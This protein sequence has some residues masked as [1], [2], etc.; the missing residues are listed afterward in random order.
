MK[1]WNWICRY[2]ELDEDF[3]GEEE[4]I[5]YS[6]SKGHDDCDNCKDFIQEY[7]IKAKE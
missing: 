4:N 1:N 5:Y 2:A 6:C 3:D 7:N